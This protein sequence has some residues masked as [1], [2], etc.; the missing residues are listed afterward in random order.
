MV[1]ALAA[2][3][4]PSA[5]SG[6]ARLSATLVVVGAGQ[7]LLWHIVPGDGAA[8]FVPGLLLAGIGSGVLNAA[9]GR[10]SVASV[11]AG[12]G[13][14]GSGANN[15]ARYL[16][17]ALGVTVVSIVAAPSGV[18]TSAALVDGWNRA[19]LVTVAVSMVGA[20][21]VLVVGSAATAPQPSGPVESAPD[22]LIRLG[23]DPN[24]REGMTTD[25]LHR[26]PSRLDVDA[27]VPTFSKA[28]SHLD[29][30]ATRELDR[31]GF[32]A[33][34]RDLVRLRASQLNG[35]AYCVDMH[36]TDAATAG[37]SAQRINAV[38]IWR[39][40]P[41]FTERER[42]ALALHRGRHPGRLH[43]R[44]GRGVRRGGG[45]LVARRGRRA[46]RA[47]R[48][49]QR[50]ERDSPSPPAPGSR[51]WRTEPGLRP[52]G[53][54]RLPRRPRRPR[55]AR[56]YLTLREAV[57]D[58]RLA[59][60]DRSR[61]PATWPD[62]SASRAARSPRPTTGS[63]PRASSRPGAGAGTY[64]ADG[65][66]R[67]RRRPARAPA[68]RRAAARRSGTRAVDRPR[69]AARRLPRP[70]DRPPRP[71]ALPPRGLAPAGLG[72]SCRRSRLAE[73]TYGGR[74]LV[75][76]CRRDRPL[77]RAVALRRRARRR[78]RRHGRARS[79]RS[80]SS[81]GCWSSPAPWSPSRTL[82][83]PPCTASSRRTARPSAAYRST[84]RASSSTPS[85]R[86]P[87]LVYVTPSHQFPTGVAM[88]LRRRAA[89]LRWAGRARRRRRR[90]RLRQR[91]PLVRPARRAAAE[92]RP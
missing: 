77:P 50:L 19:V 25:T 44:A 70:L 60:G 66:A 75:A 46:A 43:P 27:A 88:S 90:G 5:W 2:R 64:V 53:A 55:R 84:T 72:L 18:A 10:E 56:I 54:P 83:T 89:L 7:L 63:S 39:E 21:A 37:E 26:I 73:A 87:A 40:S 67:P 22:R 3:R 17:S 30:S 16:G 12:Q 13:G 69:R 33:G 49:D 80:T 1:T 14:L 6:R 65:R 58:G 36:S 68:R 48:H 74:G 76:G 79:R 29:T 78:R 34:L 45:A 8:R 32:P 52:R 20:L 9:L 4:L 62:S 35:C 41:F 51:S 59:A 42:A 47:D 81:P 86:T 11:P 31:V 91:V 28:M 57:L 85:R 23:P 82:A 38:A 24:Y 71:R 15:T 92:P 61:R